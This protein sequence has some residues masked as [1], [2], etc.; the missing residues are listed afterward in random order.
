MVYLLVNIYVVLWCKEMAVQHTGQRE[1]EEQ[2]N[3]FI[4]IS[5][6]KYK[7]ISNH[8]TWNKF[9][10]ALLVDLVDLPDIMAVWLSMASLYEFNSQI[11][12]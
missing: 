8:D 2:E 12:F 7:L 11:L 1:K 5:P 3:I 6:N 10:D 4:F 9:W